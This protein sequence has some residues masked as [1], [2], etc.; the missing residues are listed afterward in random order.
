MPFTLKDMRVACSP[1]NILFSSDLYTILYLYTYMLLKLS[2]IFSCVFHISK[3][4]NS[5]EFFKN[6]VCIQ[7]FEF[8]CIWFLSWDQF[9]SYMSY[10]KLVFKRVRRHRKITEVWQCFQSNYGTECMWVCTDCS[11]VFHKTF[12]H[13]NKMCCLSASLMNFRL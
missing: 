11:L 3:L 10:D 12:L 8:C 13:S 4:Q 5:T 2:L 7:I 1:S 9:L 6:T